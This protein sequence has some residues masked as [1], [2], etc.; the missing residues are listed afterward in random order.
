VQLGA[1]GASAD[2]VRRADSQNEVKVLIGVDDYGAGCRVSDP[3][4][5]GF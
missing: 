3:R 1:F 2:H 5:E 4:V